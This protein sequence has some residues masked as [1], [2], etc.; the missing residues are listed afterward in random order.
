MDR[1]IIRS[2]RRLATSSIRPRAPLRRTTSS[3]RLGARWGSIRIHHPDLQRKVFEI[4]GSQ[5]AEIED[6]FGHMLRAFRYGVPP[7]G[8]IAFGWD[9]IVMLLAEQDAITEVIAF[10]KT[11]SG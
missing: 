2:R 4:L 10:P 11:Q 3:Q 5:R 7:H 8:G 6:K 9:R 1:C